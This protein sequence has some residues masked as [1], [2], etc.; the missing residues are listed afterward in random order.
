MTHPRFQ[1]DLDEDRTILSV[2][3]PRDGQR[4]LESRGLNLLQPVFREVP[5]APEQESLRKEGA[6]SVVSFRQAGVADLRLEIV[7]RPELDAVDLRSSFRAAQDL[8]LNRLEI[9]PAGS[10]VNFYHCINFRN[11]HGTEHTWPELLLGREIAT[12]TYSD[13]WQFAPHPTMLGFTKLDT[14]LFVAALDLPQAFGLR[15][16]AK[17]Y[18]VEEFFLDYGQGEDGLRLKAGEQFVSPTFRIFVR[19]GLDPYQMYAE[20]GRMLID[21]R[22][23]PDP[24]EKKREAWWQEPLYCTWI[25]QC[26]A[27]DGL[28]PT[29]LVAQTAE[30]CQPTR[31]VFTEKMVRDAVEVIKRERLPIRTILLDE[32]WHVGRGHWQ[33]HPERFPDL[34]GLV[35]ELHADG[36]KVVVWW[37]WCEIEK[38]VEHLIPPGHLLAGGKRNKHGCIM[39]DYSSPET[40][41]EYLKPLFRQLFSA[42]PGCYNLDGVKTDFQADKVHADMPPADP[43]WRGEEM[44]FYRVYK[45]FY[46][47]MKKHKPDAVHIGCAGHYWLAEFIDINRTYDVF[48]S[49]YLEHE[50]R[51]RMLAAT[52][53]GCPVAYDFHNHLEHLEGYLQSARAM[54]ASVEIGNLLK[55][56]QDVGSDPAV[57]TAAYYE[58]LRKGLAPAAPAGDP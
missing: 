10:L 3:N 48:S 35:D 55:T 45:L 14:G 38:A 7:F 24:A 12:T 20:F 22:R 33:A 15:L 54:G 31:R 43:R 9:L 46:H 44:T 11:R 21:E 53:P 42:D 57:P 47:E 41:E 58:V 19:Q 40:Q 29:E 36:F 32:G 28:P 25:D 13:D 39:R 27:A 26:F 5:A 6:T 1:L 56:K 52:C 4:L 18:R 51:A 17:A 50:N 8:T 16:K 2:R 34:R 49:N 23:L 37:N 30:V